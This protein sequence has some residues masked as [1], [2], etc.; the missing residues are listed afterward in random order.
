LPDKLRETPH[1]APGEE[2]PGSPGVNDDLNAQILQVI[3]KHFARKELTG[4]P[5]DGGFDFKERPSLLQLLAERSSALEPGIN[6]VDA[7]LRALTV[8]LEVAPLPVIANENSDEGS[9]A[10]WQEIKAEA[11]RLLQAEL[12]DSPSSHLAYIQER[13]R[14]VIDHG[15]MES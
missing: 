1:A 9:E 3:K 7:Y 13:I 14:P 15:T 6:Q 2:Q 4:R 12:L 11:L 8:A 5:E 10:D